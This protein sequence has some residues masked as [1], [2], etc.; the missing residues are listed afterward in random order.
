MQGLFLSK[1]YGN[2]VLFKSYLASLLVRLNKEV[3]FIET[4]NELNDKN[5]IIHKAKM[6]AINNL[7]KK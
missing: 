6:F 5:I 3:S 2:D 4:E 7:D 1:E